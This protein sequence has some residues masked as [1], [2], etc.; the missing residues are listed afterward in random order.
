[1]VEVTCRCGWVTRGTR[2]E[3]IASV[4]A[5]GRTAHQQEITA[6]QVRAI[7]RTVEGSGAK[8]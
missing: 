3:V 4:Q 8:K 7:W 6:P 5:H 2:S 1:M